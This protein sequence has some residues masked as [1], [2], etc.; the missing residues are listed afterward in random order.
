MCWPRDPIHFSSGYVYLLTHNSTYMALFWSSTLLSYLSDYWNWFFERITVRLSDTNPVT[1]HSLAVSWRI[2]FME[3]R[4]FR[5]L[6]Q[7]IVWKLLS[8]YLSSNSH[9][10]SPW[11]S[12]STKPTNKDRNRIL[13]SMI[14]DLKKVMHNKLLKKWFSSVRI[15]AI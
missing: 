2:K 10:W 11:S 9:I 12:A 3:D 13:I 7:K 8:A 14:D 6:T 1:T 5:K 4:E 15:I